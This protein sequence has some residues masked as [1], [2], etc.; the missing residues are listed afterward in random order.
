MNFDLFSER[1]L[2]RALM[3]SILLYFTKIDE[4]SYLLLPKPWTRAGESGNN[5]S[6]CG[7]N[8]GRSSKKVKRLI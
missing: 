5:Y 7:I 1:Q 3:M 4:P 8:G 2:Q 6:G